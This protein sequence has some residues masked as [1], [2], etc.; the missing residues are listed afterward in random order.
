MWYRHDDQL[1]AFAETELYND[2]AT[3]YKLAADKPDIEEFADVIRSD[4]V[5][6]DR[7]SSDR[8]GT[9]SPRL[10]KRKSTKED[11]QSLFFTDTNDDGINGDDSNIE[12][13]DAESLF[14]KKKKTLTSSRASR[15][16]PTRV[17]A[18]RRQQLRTS[19]PQ[20]A[21]SRSGIP[22]HR[23]ESTSTTRPALSVTPSTPNTSSSTPSASDDVKIKT[24][25]D[26]DG[27]IIDL[28]KVY[29]G[30]QNKT[31][32]IS[33]TA[34]A[35]SPVLPTL[36][37]KEPGEPPYIMNPILTKIDANDFS[38]VA[39]F[40]DKSEF[41]PLFIPGPFDPETP[42][43][44]TGGLEGMT[45]SQQ[46]ADQILRLGRLYALAHKLK[47]PQMQAL[48]RKKLIAGFPNPRGW[49]SR[50]MLSMVGQV[51]QDVPG[52]VD[53]AT[54]L[55]DD[56]RQKTEETDPMKD[57]LVQWLSDNLELMSSG[58]GRGGLDFWATLD[59]T[60]GLKLAVA[61]AW[62]RNI[63]HYKGS[64]IRLP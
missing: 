6:I 11:S 15:P 45:T 3:Y 30:M 14:R 56:A 40:F 41:K 50:A 22:I 2:F 7:M 61:R 18:P 63:E 17:A 25:K 27:N 48:I 34:I 5:R 46:D 49:E 47:L 20:I 32:M 55:L 26:E 8:F 36:T 52:H 13:S 31:F 9:A 42:V 58:S 57:W 38:A 29:I 64:V 33:E 24:E 19:G 62:A 28:V 35:Q 39:Q 21:M 1:I 60:A 54:C 53:D 51:F 23:S 37:T 12:S 44:G 4:K 43:Q 59:R 10:G 16:M